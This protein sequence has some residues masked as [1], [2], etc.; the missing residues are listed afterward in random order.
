[1]P[2][3]TMAQFNIPV[4]LFVFK[5]LEP[6]KMIFDMLGK[7][8]P[9]KMYI[10]ADGPRK[11]V[12]GESDNV[13][14]VR[15]YIKNAIDWECNKQFYFFDENK[16][17]D[18]N[19]VEGLNTFFSV[20][21]KGV[22]FEDDAVP[23]EEFFPYCE[24]LLNKYQDDD[25]IQYIAGF[26]A[27]GDNSI[28]KEDYTFGKTSPMSGAI[29]T[30]ADRWTGCDFDIKDWPKYKEK[31]LLKEIYFT[32]EIRRENMR[33]LDDIYE[34]KVTAWDYKFGFDMFKKDRLAI[35]PKG[36]LATSYGYMEGAFHP[37]EKK[38]AK[39]LFEIMKCSDNRLSF[40]MRE[41]SE[42]V[43]NL[44]YDR[45]RQRKMLGVT[46]NYTERHFRYIV[47]GI[48]EICFKIIPS[49]LWNKVKELKR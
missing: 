49:G 5:R 14:E 47:R 37:Q 19:I 40:P 39:R 9:S 3:D 46:G 35:V 15:E 20:E 36:N 7:I 10:F 17:C 2:Q 45:E 21:D 48:K 28:I 44:E 38:T 13:R 23:T 18:K 16:G 42:V 26:N 8:R 1:M 33:A 4:C 11:H 25:R 41:P 24:Y 43:H 27:I 34:G 6:I 29:A 22:I 32:G 30:W 31:G 12:E